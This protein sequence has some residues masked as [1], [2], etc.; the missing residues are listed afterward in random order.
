MKY[1]TEAW[2]QERASWRAVIQLNLIRSVITIVETLEAEMANDPISTPEE[3]DMSVEALLRPSLD[4]PAC[5]PEVA[6]QLPL[7]LLTNKHL[8]LKLRLCP[9]QRVERELKRRLGAGT[10][11]DMGNE[12][13][14]VPSDTT[15]SINRRRKE[16][17]VRGWKLALNNLVR[18]GGDAQQKT[19]DQ[20]QRMDDE[21]EVIL[22]CKEDIK[23]LWTDKVVRAVLAKRRMRVEDSAGLFVDLFFLFLLCCADD[24][25]FQLCSFL[26]DIDRIATRTYE[27]S[28]YDIV[29]ARLR[30]VG[31]QEYKIQFGTDI[32]NRGSTYHYSM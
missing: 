21:T 11:E 18:H 30:T 23:A 22:G 4:A 7:D 16:F 28:D 1:A 5:E 10:E 15:L 32:G 24:T 29:R 26:D 31:V 25:F 20:G 2:K 12:G 14:G 27:P 6:Q 9:L 3:S 13:T 17:G 19:D 8:I